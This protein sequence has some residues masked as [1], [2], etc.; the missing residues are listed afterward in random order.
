IIAVAAHLLRHV[1]IGWT[2][3]A[4]ALLAYVILWIILLARMSRFPREVIKD[5]AT[6]DRGPAFL[7]IVAAT[8]VLGSQLD[9]FGVL[10]GLLPT[11]FWFS[12]G[13]WCLLVYGFLSTVTVGISKPDLE[14]GLNGAWLLLV[15][16]TESVSILG[17][18][19]A[20]HTGLPASLLFIALAFYLLG[21]MLYVLL[22]AL[23][24]FRWVF[25]P[26]SPAEMG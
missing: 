15:V 17:C 19:L 12:L 21:S 5:F 24:F 2:L 23:I 9:T 22:A 1:T 4:I 11:L 14:H 20:Q 7:T 18:L 3:F 25:R 26:M 16:A 13:L 6:H 10:T 8:G